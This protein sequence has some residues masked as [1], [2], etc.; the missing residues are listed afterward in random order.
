PDRA[1][2]AVTRP[3]GDHVAAGL[4]RAAATPGSLVAG[5]GTWDGNRTVYLLVFTLCVGM[6]SGTLGVLWGRRLGDA[7]RRRRHSHGDRGNEMK[8]RGK[9]V[10]DAHPTREVLAWT[11][12]GSGL[13]FWWWE[14]GSWGR[15]V[16][17]RRWLRGVAGWWPCVI[18][19]AGRRRLW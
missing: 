14:P 4:A 16:L 12:T 6:P 9:L 2:V 10:G 13:G 8:P 7:E 11:P 3:I 17:R 15:S 19:T 1:R 18:A 5:R